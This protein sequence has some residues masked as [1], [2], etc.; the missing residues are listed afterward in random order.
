MA[1]ETIFP[2]TERAAELLKQFYGL[3]SKQRRQAS[4]AV[5]SY[6][7]KDVLTIT[8]FLAPL[9]ELLTRPKHIPTRSIGDF[10]STSLQNRTSGSTRPETIGS[11]LNRL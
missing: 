1:A 10:I 9:G 5:E 6:F 11:F 8:E 2:E 7:S 3:S 4:T